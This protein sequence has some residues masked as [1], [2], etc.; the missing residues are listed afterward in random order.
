MEVR[1]GV[2]VKSKAGNSKEAY[3]LTFKGADAAEMHWLQFIWRDVVAE[4]PPKAKGGKPR[5]K[6]LTMPLDHSG[7]KYGLTTDPARPIWNTDAGSKIPP[8]YEDDTTVNRSQV[9]S[10]WPTSQVR[11]RT[12]PKTSLRSTLRVRRRA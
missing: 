1:T 9:R 12:M 6:R 11:W 8:F 4:F 3:T 7:R 2:S 10:P 5:M